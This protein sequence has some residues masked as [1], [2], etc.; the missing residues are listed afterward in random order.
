MSN[1]KNINNV[2]D[3]DDILVTVC[4][5]SYNRAEGLD[6]VLLCLTQQTH[7]KLQ[8]IVSDDC[9]PDRNVKKIILSHAERDQRI[10]Y[11][12][13]NQNLF[14]FKNLKFVL[15]KVAGDFVMW[16]DDDDWYHPDYVKKCLSA[17]LQDDAA[18]TAF[19]YYIETDEFGEKS[20]TYP[21]QAILLERLANK[22]T[23]MRLLAY[24]FTYN[25]YGY[26][27]IYYGLHRRSIL[28]WFNPEK[29]GVAVDMAV[30]M[31]L[32]S[33]TP[34]AL[35]REY[36]YK[37]NVGTKKEY[38]QSAL[39]TKADATYK[40]IFFKISSILITYSSIVI[41]YC[42]ILRLDHAIIIAIFAPI[43]ISSLIAISAAHFFK[44]IQ[45]HLKS[46]NIIKSIVNYLPSI[47]DTRYSN[48][49]TLYGTEVDLNK[50][51]SNVIIDSELRQILVMESPHFRCALECLNNAE[52]IKPIL[53]L[54]RSS[55]AEYVEANN[56]VHSRQYIN[57]IEQAHPKTDA[58]ESFVDFLYLTQMF[59][60]IESESKSKACVLVQQWSDQS[61][62]RF[63]LLI[64]GLHRSSILLALNESTV[65]VRVKFP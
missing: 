2:G 33:L 32:I 43:W 53:H 31:K 29:F 20:T 18:I 46:K 35:V 24:L 4:V 5:T 48:V 57:Y 1:C 56:L 9:S 22:N 45:M 6:K 19:S 8:I 49:F 16:C 47:Y 58:I 23:V 51:K 39:Y 27:N 44:K 11:Y 34:L 63:W 42:K 54:N 37:K 55:I 65:R 21:N 28:S 7:K 41:D 62:N 40:V 13:Q 50:L 36:L 38:L 10:V 17:M 15:D 3:K 59:S 14:Y 26:C 30:G 64:D 60:R 61:G 25:G 52:I 12:I